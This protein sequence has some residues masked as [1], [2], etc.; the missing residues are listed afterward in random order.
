MSNL[1]H[2]ARRASGIGRPDGGM[3]ADLIALAVPPRCVACRAPGRRAGAVLCGD[4]RRA[5]PWLT[6]APCC[7]RCAL[8]LPHAGR[9]CPARDAPFDAAWSAVAYEGVARDA[10]HALK[11]RAA[12]PLAAVMAAQISAN[13]PPALLAPGAALVPVPAHPG[14]RR[15]RGFDPAELLAR[16]LA[17]STGLPLVAVLRRSGAP[18]ARQLGASRAQRRAPGRLGIS[19]HG[20]APPEVVLVDDVHTTGATL[21]GCAQALRDA[22]AQRVSAVTWAR[23]L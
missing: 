7:T 10:M 16:A 20:P 18:A 3:V 9:R 23:T 5:L 17:R 14:R 11:F 6:R 1:N 2:E 12:R 19:A 21:S 8:P 15:R 4:C 13:A 22:G